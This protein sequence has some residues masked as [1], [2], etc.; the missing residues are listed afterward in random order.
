MFNRRVH[1]NTPLVGMLMKRL[2]MT[3][4]DAHFWDDLTYAGQT[5]AGAFE[6]VQAWLAAF[7]ARTVKDWASLP[8][9]REDCLEYAAAG[10]TAEQVDDL[11]YYVWEEDERG[12]LTEESLRRELA[13]R[14]SGIPPREVMLLLDEGEDILQ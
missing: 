14:R 11:L 12:Q 4:A 2:G 9:V 1:A 5:P 6:S 13:W 8:L 10:F 7:P 3:R